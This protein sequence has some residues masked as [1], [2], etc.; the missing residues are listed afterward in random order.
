MTS[1]SRARSPDRAILPMTDLYAGMNKLEKARA[2]VLE[3]MKR[4]GKIR[5]WRYEKLTLK[6][7]H[8]CRYTPDFFVVENDGGITLEETKGHWRDDAR[9]KI[10]VAAEQ[11]PEFTFQG[12]QL[13]K[14]VWQIETFNPSAN[15]R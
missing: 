7:A 10:R 1:I 11:F 15:V 2:I 12:V 3:A 13:A 4:A 6:L 8:D 14:G 9:V 5:S